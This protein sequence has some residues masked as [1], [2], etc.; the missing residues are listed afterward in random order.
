MNFNKIGLRRSSFPLLIIAT[1]IFILTILPLAS[2]RNFDIGNPNASLEKVYGPSD[3]ITGWI[4]ISFSSEPLSSVFSDSRENSADLSTVLE[5]NYPAYSYSCVP[6][7]CKDD[8]T[9]SSGSQT[10]TITLNWGNSKIYGVKLTG[11]IFSID[12][13]K[14]TLESTAGASCT[15]QINIDFLDDSSLDARNKNSLDE[16]CNLKNYGCF[17]SERT[18]EE[19]TIGI[20]N[21]S[22]PYCEKVILSNSPGFFIGGWIKK[23]SGS[24]TIKASIY[25]TTGGGEIANC[26]LPDA[27]S[28]GGEVSCNV[29][30]S[31]IEPKEYYVCISSTGGSGEYKIRGYDTSNGC[32]FYETPVPSEMPAAYQIFAQGKQFGAVGTLEISKSVIDGRSFAEVADEYVRKRY[33]SLNCSSGCVIPINIKSNLNQE[34]NLRDLEVNYQ[35]SSGGVTERNF[36]EI[37]KTPAKVTSGFQKFYLDGSGFSVPSNLGNYTFF[38]KLNGQSILSEKMQVKD[39]PIIKSVTPTKTASAY[40]AEFTVSVTSRYNLSGFSWDFGDNTSEIT[41]L[42]NKTSHAYNSIGVYNLRVRVTDQRQLSAS[43]V[44]VIN[45]SSPRELINSSLYDME[46]DLSNLETE[47]STFP[48]F[49]QDALNLSLNLDYIKQKVMSLKTTYQ[50]ATSEAQYNAIVTELVGLKIPKGISKSRSAQ[51]LTLFS[52]PDYVNLPVLQEIGGGTYETN[53]EED[54]VNAVLLWKQENLDVNLDFN[55]FSGR[56]TGYIEPI[57]RIFEINVDEKKDISYDYYLIIPEMEGFKTDA[58]FDVKS[59]YVYINLKEDK[60]VSFSS[61]E[62]VDFTNLPVFISPAIS[63]LTVIEEAPPEEKPRWTIFILVIFS[64][65]VIGVIGYIIMQE[66]YRRKYENYLFKNKNDLY[67][68]INYVNNAKKKGLKNNEIEGN[69][70]KAG[71]SSERIR[72]VM[73]K[74]AGRRTGMI[75]IPITKLAERAGGKPKNQK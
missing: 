39:I 58:E 67:N 60:S 68:M 27:S 61:T 17:D 53:R 43:K 33:G 65:L 51:D 50:S 63:R 66:W 29:S 12:S 9:A 30:Y 31:I 64:L 36:Y 56:Y 70:K 24:R 15:N 20:S 46:R 54:Y 21:T 74:Y 72:Y 48:Q 32:G 73:R 28:S 4:N 7:D 3:N 49:Y 8:Y 42:G 44:F 14:F 19:F 40:P 71:W 62:N 5:N 25:D 34:I 16:S 37:S 75:E 69:L 41:T 26:I 6:K 47:I 13:F 35:K 52:G 2:A 45:V 22:T 1:A 10:K 23:I 38:L 59:G 57:A 18:L 11:N 55:E